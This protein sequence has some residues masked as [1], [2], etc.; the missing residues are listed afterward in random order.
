MKFT[1][2]V[3]S[4]LLVASAV[5]FPAAAEPAKPADK[6]ESKPVEAQLFIEVLVLHATNEK[7]GIDPR[8]G[9]MRELGEPPF[10]AYDSY[11]L[12]EKVRLPVKKNE[13]KTLKLPTGRILQTRL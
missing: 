11:Q 7:H 4:A 13:V 6:A 12:L 10:S 9:E 8:I 2:F 5:T 1:G 3:V